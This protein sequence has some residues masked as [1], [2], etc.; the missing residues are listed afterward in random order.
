MRTLE[1]C[2]ESIHDSLRRSIHAAMEMPAFRACSVE[3]V[4]AGLNNR[5]ARKILNVIYTV[6]KK[7]KTLSS[8]SSS[9]TNIG[10]KAWSK[11]IKQLRST[12]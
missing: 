8:P 6:P 10:P 7:N 11:R 5:V 1:V 4:D 12:S 9:A 2:H 3:F